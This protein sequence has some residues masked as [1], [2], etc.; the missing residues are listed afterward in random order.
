MFLGE[1]HSKVC[2]GEIKEKSIFR[3]C[4]PILDF[5]RKSLLN[6]KRPLNSRKLSSHVVEVKKLFSM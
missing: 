5:L 1:V 4:L 2:F 3:E 6:F